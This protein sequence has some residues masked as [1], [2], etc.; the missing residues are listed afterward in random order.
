MKVQT[1]TVVRT[2]VLL[3]ALANQLL[4]AAGKNPLPFSEEEVYQAGTAVVTALTAIA[5][6]WKNN[7]FSQEA[8]TADE[9]M[10]TLKDSTKNEQY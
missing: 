8:L 4:T 10:K 5:A 9:Y 6:W 2:A 3:F 7:S 1:G